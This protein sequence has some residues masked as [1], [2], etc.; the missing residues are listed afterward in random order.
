MLLCRSRPSWATTPQKIAL[1]A[2]LGHAAVVWAR[3]SRRLRGQPVPIAGRRRP[4]LRPPRPRRCAAD[5]AAGTRSPA[6]RRGDADG[7]DRVAGEYVEPE[8]AY[9]SS[10]RR[11]A[12]R[13]ACAAARS[14]STGST[15]RRPTPTS[16]CQ[17]RPRPRDGILVPVGSADAGSKARSARSRSRA[18]AGSPTW[19]SALHAHRGQRVARNVA[20]MPGANSTEST[21]RPSTR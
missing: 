4:H 10:P 12:T 1:F 16:G 5:L 15:P 2:S 17:T 14:R 19:G 7:P 6:R 8:D 9:L 21:S 20:G 18:S 13:Y 11:S 3:T